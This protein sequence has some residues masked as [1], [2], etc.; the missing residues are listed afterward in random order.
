[1]VTIDA[2]GIDIF[3]NGLIVKLTIVRKLKIASADLKVGRL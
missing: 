2:I 1:M 3:T